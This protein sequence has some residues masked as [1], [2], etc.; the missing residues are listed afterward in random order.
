[1][2]NFCTIT[3]AG[4]LSQDPEMRASQSGI[5][6]CTCSI[7]FNRKRGEEQVACFVPLVLFR[8]TAERFNEW[9]H[10]GDAVLVHGSLQQESWEAQDGQKRSRLSMIVDRFENLTPRDKSRDEKPAREANQRA[11]GASKPPEADYVDAPF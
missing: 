1:M 8:D 10:K 6:V 2:P 4:H 7:A 5:A 11:R 3:I 9:M